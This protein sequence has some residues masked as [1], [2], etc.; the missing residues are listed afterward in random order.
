MCVLSVPCII[1]YFNSDHHHPEISSSSS[2]H[3]FFWDFLLSFLFKILGQRD[4]LK[5][6]FTGNLLPDIWRGQV[7]L[8]IFFL[9]K[10]SQLQSLTIHPGTV[11]PFPVSPSRTCYALRETHG[12]FFATFNKFSDSIARRVTV[13]SVSS[14]SMGIIWYLNLCVYKINKLKV[15]KDDS[16]E[17]SLTVIYFLRNTKI[18]LYVFPYFKIKLMFL[19]QPLLVHILMWEINQQEKMITLSLS[20]C[21]AVLIHPDRNPCGKRNCL[22]VSI[23]YQNGNIMVLIIKFERSVLSLQL[24]SEDFLIEGDV[25]PKNKTVITE[26]WWGERGDSYRT[27]CEDICVICRTGES[28]YRASVKEGV[29]REVVAASKYLHSRELGAAN[30][31]EEEPGGLVLKL[32][33]GAFT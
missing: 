6:F 10:V 9:P 33:R 3:S 27:F 18:L 26:S 30:R 32:Q 12:R 24:C 21:L 22:A 14:N 5:M 1:V 13:I 31:L 4:S 28:N 29:K 7:L 20:Y 19:F 11:P 17:P 2:M 23:I 8:L 15:L 25:F 16:P